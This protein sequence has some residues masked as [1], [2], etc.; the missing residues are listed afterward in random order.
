MLGDIVVVIFTVGVGVGVL[1]DVEGL[2]EEADHGGGTQFAQKLLDEYPGTFLQLGLY[3]VDIL[4]DIPH[5]KYDDNLHRL[6]KWLKSLKRPVY[7]RIGYEFD[8]PANRYDPEQYIRAYHYIV[9]FLKT[10]D[11][12][13]VEYVWHSYA[14]YV[15][16]GNIKRWYPGDDYVDWIAV[17]F[18][19]AYSS[20]FR[21]DVVR[22]AMAHHKPLMIAESTPYKIGVMKSEQ[23][24]WL[25]FR[26]YFEFIQENDVKMF[27]YINWDWEQYP[28]FSGQGW[29]NGRI[30]D[31]PYIKEKWIEQLKKSGYIQ[32]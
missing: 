5:G 21:R 17:S 14:A 3:L 28:L 22:I 10:F 9:D 2:W 12:M 20:G 23:S 31:N 8:N 29:G 26:K 13:N 16:G 11:V 32:P 18:Y 7:L 24:W 15:D 30:Q 4:P 6:A 25:W 19:D 27:C 1:Q